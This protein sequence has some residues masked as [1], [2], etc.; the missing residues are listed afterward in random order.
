M[1]RSHAFGWLEEMREVGRKGATL[2]GIRTKGLGRKKKVGD[3]VKEYNANKSVVWSL[4]DPYLFQL[5]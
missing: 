2:E 5:A 4:V 3:G 1:Q